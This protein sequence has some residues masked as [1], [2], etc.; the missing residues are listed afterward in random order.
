MRADVAGIVVDEVEPRIRELLQA[1]PT[2]TATV[3]AERVGWERSIRVLS[4]RVAELR[5]VC[6]PP[7]PAGRTSYV[8]G[9]IAQCDFWFPPITLLVGFGQTRGLTQLPVL[10]MVAGYSRWASGLLVPTRGAE[11]LFAGSWQLLTGL[12]AVP[13]VLVWDRE[14]AI[15]RWRGG[16]TELT[17]DC[18]G[19]RGTLGSKVLVCKPRDPEAKGSGR[20]VPRLPARGS[21]FSRR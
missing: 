19:F 9:E 14:G 10:T 13:R 21:G 17:Q 8:A 5:P 1:W 12:G 2:M 11:D 20:A 3:I 16:K 18:Q 7:D 6:L 15:G 4:D